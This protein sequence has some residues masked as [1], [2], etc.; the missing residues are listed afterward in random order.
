M[1]PYKTKQTFDT[2][3]RSLRSGTFSNDAT[4]VS[5]KRPSRGQQ[6]TVPAGRTAAAARGRGE[7]AAASSASQTSSSSADDSDG[8]DDAD[9]ADDGIDLRI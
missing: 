7:S 5:K 3:A 4:V 8:S 2:Y 6:A 1:P 9:G